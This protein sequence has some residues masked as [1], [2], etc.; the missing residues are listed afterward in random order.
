MTSMYCHITW[1]SSSSAPQISRSRDEKPENTALEPLVQ[2]ALN[3]TGR[4]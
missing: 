2:F 4:V 3:D 1:V